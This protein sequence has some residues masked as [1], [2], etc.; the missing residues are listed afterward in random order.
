[1]SK[2]SNFAYNGLYL[3]ILHRDGCEPQ[4]NSTLPEVVMVGS[5]GIEPAQSNSMMTIGLFDAGSIQ[6]LVA[7]VGSAGIEPA[8]SNFMMTIGLFDAG[9]I[10]P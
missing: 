5:A 2:S 9:S 4:L 3:L 1:M 6:P 8:Q 10:Q 7:M